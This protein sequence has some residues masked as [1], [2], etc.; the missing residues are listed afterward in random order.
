MRYHD[1]SYREKCRQRQH[2]TKTHFQ[3]VNFCTINRRE[4]ITWG[5][6][7]RLCM[8]IASGLGVASWGSDVYTLFGLSLWAKVC[9]IYCACANTTRLLDLYSA[10]DGNYSINLSEMQRLQVSRFSGKSPR[11][12][13]LLRYTPAL[14]L[15]VSSLLLSFR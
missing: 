1:G 6:P 5:V 9:L 11:F 7:S 10:L 12:T 3:S 15:L 8:Y 14:T 4:L 13:L 2:R